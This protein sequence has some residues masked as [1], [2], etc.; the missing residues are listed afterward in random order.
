MGALNVVFRKRYFNIYSVN[1]TEF[2]V[3]NSK[4]DFNSHHTHIRRFTTAKYILNM[5][6]HKT[7][8][9]R[10]CNYHIISLIRL[11]DD[12]DYIKKLE[13]MLK[14]NKE[15]RKGTSFKSKKDSYN[16]KIKR[17]K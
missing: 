12:E 1:N 6:L 4:L 7:I 10:L 8:P 2:I 9:K 11:T 15:N 14:I 13:E 17:R 3:H 5:S 16:N